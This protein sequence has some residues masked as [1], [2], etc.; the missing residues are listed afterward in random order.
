MIKFFRKIR[1]NMISERKISR[2]LIYA[3]GE[4]LL[5]VIGILLALQI[6]NGNE[7][8]KGHIKSKKY[9][10]EILKD[11][12]ADT[13]TIKRSIHFT[14]EFIASE[15]WALNKTDFTL[16]DVDSLWIILEGFYASVDL[17]DRTFQKIQNS[18]ESSLLGFDKMFDKIS[19]YY[20]KTYNSYNQY[21][22]WDRKVILEGQGY[23]QDLYDQLEISNY[24]M[25]LLGRE[26]AVQAFPVV[27]DSPRQVEKLIEFAK[28]PRGRNH[29]RTNYVR[30]LRG[31]TLFESTISEAIDLINEIKR[32]LEAK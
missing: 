4:I 1:Q 31:I 26:T 13:S 2:Y 8:R 22:D 5:V 27:N 21:S 18:G 9:L 24:R 12:A 20:T 23:L 10:A 16:N 25:E 15:E 28:S 19:H 11:L 6:N 7:N 29:L 32:V 30:H 17:H 14:S 3:I